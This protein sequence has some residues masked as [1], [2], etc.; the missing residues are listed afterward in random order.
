MHIGPVG[1]GFKSSNEVAMKTHCDNSAT[2]KI[3]SAGC[4]ACGIPAG[5]SVAPGTRGSR[6]A[7][8]QAS[9]FAAHVGQ[10]PKLCLGETH[11]PTFFLVMREKTLPVVVKIRYARH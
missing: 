8:E 11:V 2:S 10:V 4:M 1:E 7:D 6:V 3:T 5:A 9:A